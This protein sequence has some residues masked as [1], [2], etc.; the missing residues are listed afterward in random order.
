MAIAKK[1]N[2]TLIISPLEFRHFILDIPKVNEKYQKQA[3]QFALKSYYPGTDENT[4]IDY[5][6][7]NSKV[8]GIAV[9]T[10]KLNDVQNEY[11]NIISPSLVIMNSFK[12]GILICCSK[13]W[14]ELQSVSE[15][16]IISLHTFSTTSMKSA[17]RKLKELINNSSFFNDK[18]TLINNEGDISGFETFLHNEK[19]EYTICS[20]DQLLGKASYSNICIFNK[21]EGKSKGLIFYLF[22]F[23][24]IAIFLT[25]LI[26]TQT[27]KRKLENQLQEIKLEYNKLKAEIKENQSFTTKTDESEIKQVHSL[28][29]II[30]EIGSA[31]DSLIINSFEC[32]NNTIRFEAEN[33]NA[34][35]VLANL[36]KSD[37]IYDITLIQ[38]IPKDDGKEK[39]IITGKVR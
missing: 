35:E 3:V 36:N 6:Y 27:T 12:E 17:F 15:G 4:A 19:Q 22:V 18:I 7:F 8:I 31:S 2:K 13:D 10:N 1:N 16:E 14:I 24:V 23:I 25:T 32:I 21:K 37:F 34:I 29:E 11:A 26:Y 39:F 33:A 30:S 9:S 20:F 5:A 38:S 28:Q